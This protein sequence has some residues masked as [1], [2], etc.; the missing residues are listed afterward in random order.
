MN[1][2]YTVDPMA[3]TPIMLINKHIGNDEVEGVGIMG[4]QFQA[5]LLAL[6]AMGKRLIDVWITSE[7]GNVLEGEKIYGAILKCSAKVDTY[8]MGMAAS[9]AAVIFQAGRTRYMY[10]FSKLMFHEVSGAQ[11]SELAIFNS[12][13]ATMISSRT[14][15][16]HDDVLGM[17]KRT[18]WMLAAEALERGFCDSIADSNEANR[19]RLAKASNIKDFHRESVLI[20]NKAVEEKRIPVNQNK[21]TMLKV[22]NRLG[23][24]KEANEDAID[25][26]VGELQNKINAL[27]IENK[28]KE[29]ALKEAKDKAEKA[30]K[31]YEDMKNGFEKLDEEKKETEKKAK[32]EKAKNLIKTYAN[33]FDSSKPEVVS[34]WEKKAIEDYDG[35][36]ALLDSIPVNA[37]AKNLVTEL[38]KGGENGVGTDNRKSGNGAHLQAQVINNRKNK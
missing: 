19:G 6:C 29:D 11:P 34:N 22:T 9:I 7:G 14:G 3:E 33:R 25:A 26:A 21:H 32:E 16:S 17:M 15:T 2:I 27:E 10:D 8:C 13:I 31:D 18:T 4:D 35:T 24:N 12:T 1:F 30:A 36:K 20:M 5:E 23:L 38:P 37:K 28:S